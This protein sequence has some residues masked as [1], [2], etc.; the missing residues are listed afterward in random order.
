MPRR[1]CWSS[2]E[3]AGD[4]GTGTGWRAYRVRSPRP[5]SSPSTS[6]TRSPPGGVPGF[7]GKSRSC[8][9]LSAGYGGTRTASASTDDGSVRSAVRPWPPGRA[10]GGPDAGQPE[11]RRP[12]PRRRDVVGPVDLVRPDHA[13][14]APAIEMFLGCPPETCPR[15]RAAASPTSHVTADDPPMLIVNSEQEFVPLEEARGMAARLST[16]RVRHRLW[17]L[18]GTR[19]ATVYTMTALGPSIDFLRRWLG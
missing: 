8:A 16:A 7:R 3:A 12:R 19:H 4:P 13:P 10:A 1:R 2:T 5:A 9:V 18:P 14:L 17:I 15:R 11:P 6:T